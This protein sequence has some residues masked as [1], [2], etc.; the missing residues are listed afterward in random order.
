[1][2][3]TRTIQIEVTAIL[4]TDGNDILPAELVERDI[5]HYFRQSDQVNVTVKDFI[6][7]DE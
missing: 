7:E 5:K 3:V 2:E 4:E 1:M 6:R